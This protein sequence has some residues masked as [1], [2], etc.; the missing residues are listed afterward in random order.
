MSTFNYH[1]TY[2]LAATGLVLGMLQGCATPTTAPTS[3]SSP[4]QLTHCVIQEVLPG[5]HA[6][7]AYLRIHHQGK[8]VDIVKAEVPSLSSRVEL[9]SMEMRN[10]VMLMRPMTNLRLPAG[11]RVFQKGGDHVM[12]FD[13]KQ[14]PAIGS[15]HT[16][17]LHFSNGS[18]ASCTAT[19]KSFQELVG[20]QK[21]THTHT[22]H[23][24]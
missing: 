18:S 6:T 23:H 8:P 4:T 15:L 24:H 19:V 16:L 22:H 5:R 10:Q 3:H 14:P 12:L 17:R 20:Q 1:I 21:H 7:G 9:H 13:I 2:T 11:E